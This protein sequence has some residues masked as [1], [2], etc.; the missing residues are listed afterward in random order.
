MS[1]VI[2]DVVASHIS[3]RQQQARGKIIS[4]TA[5]EYLK[6]DLQHQ[7]EPLRALRDFSIGIDFHSSKGCVSFG[8]AVKQMLF[9]E[10]EFIDGH[11]GKLTLR[12]TN[13]D[14]GFV[15]P[16]TSDYFDG[17]DGLEKATERCLNNL[18]PALKVLV[19]E[20]AK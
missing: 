4:Y 14:T 9:F 1:N 11:R 17:L 18:R 19:S 16:I 10:I 20:L 6:A 15:M 12:I 5:L 3:N 2:K 13:M 8:S 7:L